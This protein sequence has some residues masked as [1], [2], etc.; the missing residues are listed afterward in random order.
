MSEIDKILENQK[1]QLAEIERVCSKYLEDGEERKTERNLKVKLLEVQTIWQTIS[2]NSENLHKL[3]ENAHEYFDDTTFANVFEQYE[4]VV[5]DINERLNA[6]T[7]V[8]STTTSTTGTISKKKLSYEEN[9]GKKVG[10]KSNVHINDENKT[11]DDSNGKNKSTENDSENELSGSVSSYTVAD[12]NVNQMSMLHL[13]ISELEEFL[14][15]SSIACAAKSKGYRKAQIEMI[16]SSWAEFRVNYFKLKSSNNNLNIDYTSLQRRFMEVVAE[17]NDMSDENTSSQT[18]IILPKIKLPEFDGTSTAWST[19]IGLFNKIVHQNNT[20]DNGIKMQYLK[21]SLSGEAAKIV[22][23]ISPIAENYELCYDLLQKRFNNKREILGKLLDS[24]LNLPKQNSENFYHLKNLHDTTFECIMSIKNLNIPVDQW[25]PLITHILLKKLSK[26]TITNYECQLEDTREI[27]SLVKFLKYIESR[28]LA[29]QSASSN[30]EYVNKNRSNNNNNYNNEKEIKCVYCND[31]HSIMKCNAFINKNVNERFE[32]IK[33]KKLCVNCF[34][35]HKKGECVSKY[36]CSK[37]HKPHNTLLHFESKSQVTN[38]NIATLDEK[39]NA[40]IVNS[41]VISKGNNVLLA[42]AIIAVQSASGEKIALRALIDQGSQNAFITGNA[43][44]ILKIRRGNINAEVSG[45]GE[46]TQIAKH[47]IGINISPRFDSEYQIHVDA[48]ILPKLTKFESLKENGK[49]DH[50]NNL[51]L[52]DPSYSHGGKID[53]ILGAA[54]YS[55]I[56]KAGLIKGLQNQPIAQN[57]ELGW[58]VSGICGNSCVSLHLNVKIHMTNVNLDETLNRLFESDDFINENSQTDEE[59]MCEEHFIENVKRDETGK[60]VVKMPFKHD[61]DL[62]DS[63]KSALATFFHLE[64]RFIRDPKLKDEYTKFIHEYLSMNH[65]ELVVNE[66]NNPIHYLPHHSVIKKDSTT[67]KLR[68]VFNASNK[69]SNG[70][71]LNEQMAIG[72]SSQSSLISLILKWR[73][74]KY[75][76]CADIEKMYRQI[77]IHDDQVDLQRILWRNSSNETIKEYRLKTVTYGTA[78]AP[79]LAIRTLF[80]LACDE[81]TNHPIASKIIKECMYVDDLVHGA[82]SE[83]EMNIIYDQ[84]RSALSAGGFNLRKWSSNSVEFLAKIPEIDREIV[85]NDLIKTLGLHWNMSTDELSFEI[86]IPNEKHDIP[87]TKRMLLSQIASFFDP[88]GLISPVIIGAKHLIQST[89]KKKIDWDEKV[90]SEIKERWLALKNELHL[91]KTIKIKRW[92]HVKNNS[93]VELHGFCDASEK[94]YAAVIYIKT[95]DEKNSTNVTLLTAKARVA[96]IKGSK[97]CTI[98]RLELCGAL[99]LSYLTRQTIDSMKINFDKIVMWTD[100]RIALAWINGNPNRWRTFVANKVIKINSIIDKSHWMHIPGDD[101]PA[102]YPSRGVL[103]SRLINNSLWWHGPSFLMNEIRFN[104]MNEK[105]D[106][107]LESKILALTVSVHEREYVLPDSDSYYKLKRIIAYCFLFAHN[108]RNKVNKKYQIT[109]NELIQA[110][111]GIVKNIQNDYFFDEIQALKANKRIK[112]TSKLLQLSP[113]LDENEIIRVGGRLTNANISFDAKHQILLPHNNKVVKLLIEYTHLRCIHGGPKLTEAILRERFWILKGLHSI[114]AVYRECIECFKQNPSTLTQKMGNLPIPRI[115]PNLKP[116]TNSAVDYTGEIKTSCWKGRGSKTQKSYAAIFVCMA[117][118]AIH[119]EIVS[120]LTAE[121]FIAAL[122]RFVARRGFVSNIYSDNATNFAKANKVLCEMNEYEQDEYHNKICDELSKTQIKWHFSPAAAPHFNGLAES[123][124]KLVKSHLRKIA[125]NHIFT[126]EEL[127]TL[128]YQIEACVN[129]RPL[130]GVSNNAGDTTILTPAHFLIGQSMLAIPCENYVE[131]KMNWATR[132]QKIQKLQQNFWNQWK[133]EY[134]SLLQSRYKWQNVEKEL[135]EQDIVLIKDELTPSTQWSMAKILKKHPGSDGNTRVVTLKSK[136]KIFK[137]PI[138]KLCPLPIKNNNIINEKISANTVKVKKNGKHSILSIISTMLMVF[139]ANSMQAN[140]NNEKSFAISYFDKPPL[141]YFEQVHTA[142]FTSTKWNIVTYLDLHEYVTEL[143][144]IRSIFGQLEIMCTKEQSQ[145]LIGID[146]CNA[147]INT[148]GAQINK[149]QNNNDIIIGNIQQRK[150][151]ATLDIIGNIVGDVFGVLDSRFAA[152]Y[153]TDLKNLMENDEHL[154][155]LLR[156]QTSVIDATLN[157]LQQT[158]SEINRQNKYLVRTTDEIKKIATT[159]EATNQFFLL[160]N[161]LIRYENQQNAILNIVSNAHDSGVITSLLTS[162][163]L[164]NQLQVIRKNVNSEFLVPE[165]GFE[166]YKIL[167]TKMSRCGKLLFFKITVPLISNNKFAVFKMHAVPTVHENMYMEIESKFSYILTT[168]DRRYYVYFHQNQL[169]KCIKY[170][171][172]TII[173]N[174][175]LKLYVNTMAT[176]EWEILNHVQHMESNCKIIESPITDVW[177]E[178]MEEN[179]WIF[180]INREY[181]FTTTCNEIISHHTLYGEGILTL[182]E[183]CTIVDKFIKL[184]AQKQINNEINP[185]VIPAVH[186]TFPHQFIETANFEDKLINNNITA[187]INIVS[188]MKSKT[189]PHNVYNHHDVHHYT[190]IYVLVA[191]IAI[192]FF[193]VWKREKPTIQFIHQQPIPAPRR[194]IQTA[195]SMPVLAENVEI[196]T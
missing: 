153:S 156:N 28:F 160:S 106:T 183:N 91:L 152:K 121:A 168:I 93:R 46:K 31:L 164:K 6:F 140:V 44:Q 3:D 34:K 24:I 176:C 68:V 42:T 70:K 101:N 69:M 1:F 79:Y 88:L 63:K 159:Q 111:I 118:K 23:H 182:N 157:I 80:K 41:H 2:T 124:V 89:W 47:F 4:K 67:T 155:S 14:S 61:L 129:S 48:I 186:E 8:K 120:D 55:K 169:E 190:W 83:N 130:C 64:K 180:V 74:Y 30:N 116:F 21:T 103:P 115:T 191:A 132:W 90:P 22:N 185:V 27:Q 85:Q 194:I 123:S 117:T 137:R 184:T 76:M 33:G 166:L 29:L 154:S 127:C 97:N 18:Q 147:Y 107:E 165:D 87:L 174:R 38:A 179:Y 75:A 196:S 119:I 175:P 94:S 172:D 170:H 135:N 125:H 148:L 78:N 177:I 86:N 136:N 17:L 49:Y 36:T 102:D 143:E 5:N 104:N 58:I 99:L 73:Q 9:N 51:Q 19:F 108:C 35:S 52:A 16:K 92:I 128:L 96:P 178:L 59:I 133:R 193:L 187:L 126:Y 139:V 15:V 151:R 189:L 150:K 53:V 114:K 122:R 7:Q 109:T 84:L 57:T 167:T 110:E 100:S 138:T 113:F 65:M 56:L 158:E 112:N 45:V 50:L 20:I 161:I 77:W 144:D 71:T 37:C 163:Q 105:F 39:E 192:L 43:A 145:I 26:E 95:I 81:E 162:E 62:G 13:Q 134:L 72:K 12:R 173:C 66:T 25:D 54:E 142:Y 32:Y 181:Q 141:I 40:E 98:P 10:E 131:M 188:E 11:T 149:L 82:H 195:V 171:D 60:Y 146:A